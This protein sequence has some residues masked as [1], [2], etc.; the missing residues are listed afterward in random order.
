MEH[1]FPRT[2]VSLT[3]HRS[4]SCCFELAV[5][6]LNSVVN[7][8]LS[9]LSNCIH[10]CTHVTRWSFG[11]STRHIRSSSHARRSQSVGFLRT[12][13]LP[14]PY[15]YICARRRC[16]HTATVCVSRVC[17][18]VS[19]S[20][21]LLSAGLHSPLRGGCLPWYMSSLCAH[22]LWPICNL[23]SCGCVL[24]VALCGLDSARRHAPSHIIVRVCFT[25]QPFLST[26]LSSSP[27]AIVSRRHSLLACPLSPAVIHPLL[28]LHLS[29]HFV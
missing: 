7:H 23:F 24:F 20:S 12:L 6:L 13:A 26:S 15:S 18:C 21:S 9:P 25:A 5:D 19:V 4:L 3:H 29:F 2:R 8:T 14:S 16:L 22:C 1:Y 10:R 27:A 11:E 28:H 17:V